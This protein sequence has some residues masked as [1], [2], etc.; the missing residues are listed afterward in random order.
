MANPRW[1][2]APHVDSA[3]MLAAVLHF[4][5]TDR[6]R[7]QQMLLEGQLTMIIHESVHSDLPRDPK[8]HYVNCP[9]PARCG[10]CCRKQGGYVFRWLSPMW[11]DKYEEL[12]RPGA[13]KPGHPENEV[14]QGI[15]GHTLDSEGNILPADI[16]MLPS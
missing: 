12:A 14:P 3:A 16:T 6:Q 7:W 4:E 2:M 1:V 5:T 11:A 10:R 15:A 8:F 9:D 13:W